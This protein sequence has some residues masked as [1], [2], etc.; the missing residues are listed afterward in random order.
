[1]EQ[2]AGRQQVVPPAG[3]PAAAPGGVRTLRIAPGSNVNPNL[4]QFP[5]AP[6]TPYAVSAP[7]AATASAEHAGYATVIF[8]NA[9]GKAL[10]RDFLCSSPSRLTLG[11]VT[12]DADGRFGLPLPQAMAA[13]QP[14]IRAAFAGDARLR[15]ALA[16]AGQ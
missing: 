9:Q 13:A 10:K 6:G 5:V 16:I 12:T 14:E 2:G 7:I 8:L 15:G 4:K 3:N 1:R 11:A